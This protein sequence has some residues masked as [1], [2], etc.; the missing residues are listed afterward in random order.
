M[1]VFMQQ[2]S[3]YNKNLKNA[4]RAK[5]R[6]GIAKTVCMLR[7]LVTIL[8]TSMNYFSSQIHSKHIRFTKINLYLT[9]MVTAVLKDI[10]DQHKKYSMARNYF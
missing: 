10:L 2:S 1:K 7:H 4:P 6:T 9:N 8:P 3:S 5:Y